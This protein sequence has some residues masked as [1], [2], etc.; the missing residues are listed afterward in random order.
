MN[1]PPL[2]MYRMSLNMKAIHVQCLD[3]NKKPVEGVNASGFILE[4]KGELFVYTCWHL[5][6]GYNMHDVKIGRTL[7]NRRFIEI[8][9]QDCDKRQPGVQVI[10]GNQSIIISLYNEDNTPAWIQNQQDVPHPDLNAINLKIPFWHDAVKIALP[11]EITLSKMQIIKEDEIWNNLLMIGEKI[12]IV[13][14]PYGYSALGM[15]QPTAIVLTRFLA[16]DRIKDRQT[17]MLLDGPGAPGMSGGPAFIERDN[18]LHLVGIYT[19]L[20]YPDH[21]IEKNEK[22]T[23]LGTFS[24]MNLWWRIENE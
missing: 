2:H 17:E 12:Y 7:P 10:G 6:T 22:T 13:G 23:A 21:V 8:N 16:A 3:K 18:T 5:V 20:I 15:E 19:G 11:R 24:N 4:E 1:K 9:L 14:F